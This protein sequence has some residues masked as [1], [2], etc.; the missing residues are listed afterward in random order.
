MLSPVLT[1]TI[2]SG[3]EPGDPVR[4]NL[5]IQDLREVHGC[6]RLSEPFAEPLGN[7]PWH[8]RRHIATQACNL[9]HNGRTQKAVPSTRQEDHRF[10]IRRKRLV[11]VRKLQFVVEVRN[12]T[13]PAYERA[14]TLFTRQI[15]GQSSVVR[16]DTD[17]CHAQ[18]TNRF[19]NKLQ[20]LRRAE[21]RLL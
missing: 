13:Q 1:H 12:G 21:Q 19:F 3:H 5:R 20:P 14:R 11:H 16:S 2:I 6:M 4:A 9:S 18:V 15:C 17:I 7:N 10:D 8:P